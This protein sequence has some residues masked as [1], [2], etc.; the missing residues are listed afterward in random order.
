[1]FCSLLFCFTLCKTISA[2]VLNFFAAGA[3]IFN[4]GTTGYLGSYFSFITSSWICTGIS[5]T[6][7]L[8]ISGWLVASGTVLSLKL[9]VIL[10]EDCLLTTVYFCYPASDSCCKFLLIRLCIS[11]T[12]SNLLTGVSTVSAYDVFSPS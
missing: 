8:K 4:F 10:L 11:F 3:I 9:N 2:A 12:L 6:Q 1:M 7:G 5:L